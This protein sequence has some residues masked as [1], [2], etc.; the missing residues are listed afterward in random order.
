[1]ALSG[2]VDLSWS[3]NVVAA[4]LE[5]PSSTLLVGSSVRLF[6]LLPRAL[7]SEFLHGRCIVSQPIR[8]SSCG[9]EMGSRFEQL[10]LSR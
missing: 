5:P 1:M 2:K 9:I 7:W 6:V 4:R 3:A 8:M 10:V